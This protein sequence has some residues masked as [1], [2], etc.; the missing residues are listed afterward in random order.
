VSKLVKSLAIGLGGLVLLLL[1]VAGLAVAL[2]DAN[3]FKTQIVD[4][5]K[6]QTGR[7]LRIDAPIDLK[8][9]PWLAVSLG[10]VSLSN[11]PGFGDAPFLRV[12]EVRAR[13]KLLP[14]LSRRVEADSLVVKGLELNLGKDK[15]GKANWEGLGTVEKGPTEGQPKAAKDSGG[16]GG[17]AA[18]GLGGIDVENAK[19]A[20]SD[21]RSG[22]RYTVE[23]LTLHTGPVSLGQ[24][25]PV[26]LG[27]TLKADAPRWQARIDGKGN[28]TLTEAFGVRLPDLAL[29]MKADGD[30]LPGG[31]MGIDLSAGVD[32]DPQAQTLAV[33][34]LSVSGPAVKVSGELRGE[35][36]GAQPAFRGR[37]EVGETNVRELLAA[38][39]AGAIKTADPGVLK[40]LTAKLELTAN[41]RSA[42][43]GKLSLR[44]DDSE[45]SGRVA[46][47]DF[48]GPA[49]RFDLKLNQMDLDRYLPPR[50]AEKAGKAGGEAK[51]TAP[52]PGAVIPLA[53]LRA[54]DL[55]G[56]LAVGSL[57]SAGIRMSD[58]RVDL[59][60]KGGVVEKRVDG[61][62]YEGTAGM[63]VGLDARQATPGLSL[64]ASIKG[65]KVGPFLKD[66]MGEDRLTGTGDVDADLRWQGLDERQI[67]ES[68]SGSTRLAFRDGAVKGFNIGELI[69]NARAKLT[70]GQV[71]GGPQQTDFS[72]LSGSATIKNGVIA[73][74][75]LQAK[76]PLLRVVGEGTVNLPAE[77]IDYTTT[78]TIVG[79][80]EGQGGSELKELQGIP[81][82][83]HFGG[84]LKDPSI[85]VDLAKVLEGK[86]KDEAKKKIE[87]KIQEK[88]PGKGGDVL[89][90]ILGR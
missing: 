74:R 85:K 27:V 1:V 19:I 90:G 68:L 52:P 49:Y 5:V 11:A 24:P 39:G 72:E 58:V 83:V 26:K 55:Q 6:A 57:K 73:N 42:E 48:T 54:L 12:D 15:A 41:D 38:F 3:A 61:R 81:I 67:K 14:L 31:G 77:K 89:R 33:A 82:P 9:F 53:P 13:V 16:A 28:L 29:T 34:P 59:K 2:F 86:V 23:G 8:L 30:G 87:E 62:L 4:V 88:L 75:D 21:Q 20:W 10:K 22:G 43:A 17:L 69:R 78:V 79:S 40:K 84:N 71:S 25:F 37:L 32:Y 63:T 65:L 7:E 64:K 18:F 36:L 35:N 46:I 50:S 70:G 51:L 60:A 76:S 80:L 56:K 44:L 66:S 45:I 47:A